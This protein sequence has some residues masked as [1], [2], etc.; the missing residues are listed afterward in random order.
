VGDNVYGLIDLNRDGAAVEFVAVHA[1]DL[2]AK[3]HR[4]S[5]VDTAALPLAA[6]TAWQA[7]VDHATVQLGQQVLVLGGAGGVGVYAVQLAASLGAQVTAVDLPARADMVRGL[8]A[9]RFVDATAEPIEQVVSGMDLAIDTV[10][11]D[12]LRRAYGALRPGGKMITLGAPPPEG[13]A[14]QYGVEAVFFIVRP[15]RD[16]LTELARQVDDGRSRPVVS[17]TFPLAEGRRAYESAGQPRPPG[18][19]VLTV[20]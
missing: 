20:V 6:L 2:A 16:E 9:Q 10:G 15:D 18:K 12:T 11:G 7:L 5:H 17:Q 14:D 4:A 13:L 1:A 19:T 8:G 3:P